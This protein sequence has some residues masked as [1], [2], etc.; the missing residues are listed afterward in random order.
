MFGCF[1]NHVEYIGYI[2]LPNGRDFNQYYTRDRITDT[3]EFDMEVFRYFV[4]AIESMNNVIDYIYFD[5]Y[6]ELFEHVSLDEFR[7]RILKEYPSMSKLSDLANAYKHS[8]RAKTKGRRTIIKEDKIKSAEMNVVEIKADLTISAAKISSITKIISHF[9]AEYY[10]IFL[11]NFL[12]WLDYV[13]AGN[14]NAKLRSIL[15]VGLG[16]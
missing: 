1:S 8:V 15:D 9:R 12:Y 11:E 4:N 13:G 10:N 2:V 16:K 5:N 3:I 14:R 6:D 7:R